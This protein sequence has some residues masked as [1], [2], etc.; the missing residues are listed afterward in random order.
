MFFYRLACLATPL[1]LH[2]ITARL[3]SLS[4]EL[5]CNGSVEAGS[6]PASNQD[7]LK[8]LVE[9]MNA[10]FPQYYGVEWVRQTARHVAN[11]AQIDSQCLF[12]AS[13]SSFTD[14]CQI[15]KSQPNMYLRMIWT[16]DVCISKGRQPEEFDFPAWLRCLLKRS[17]GSRTRPRRLSYTT[18]QTVRQ[19]GLIDD[20]LLAF[21]TDPKLSAADGDMFGEPLLELFDLQKLG[22]SYDQQR[23]GIGAG[24]SSSQGGVDRMDWDLV[25][26]M[27]DATENMLDRL[28][29]DFMA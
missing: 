26:A 22:I 21:V 19:T 5:S 8:V 17:K 2:T 20:G 3:S 28:G 18:E 14:W 29:A 1:T 24:G 6:T 13:G 4:N 16:V 12:Q 27:H 11:L 23:N 15:L 25:E 10:F 7:R 9:T